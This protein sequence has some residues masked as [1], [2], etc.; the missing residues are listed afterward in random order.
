MT[1]FSDICATSDHI[2]SL[3][4]TALQLRQQLLHGLVRIWQVSILRIR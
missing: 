3:N 2:P 4:Y 1:I